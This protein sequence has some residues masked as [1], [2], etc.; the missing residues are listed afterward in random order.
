MGFWVILHKAPRFGA[1]DGGAK[2]EREERERDP[3]P[4]SVYSFPQ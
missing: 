1:L 2:R 4:H 3:L